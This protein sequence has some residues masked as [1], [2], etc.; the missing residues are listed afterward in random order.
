M[1]FKVGGVYN[2]RT[3]EDDMA[4]GLGIPIKVTRIADGKIWIRGA[5]LVATFSRDA[6]STWVDTNPDRDNSCP[7]TLNDEGNEFTCFLEGY[8]EQRYWHQD[9]DSEDEHFDERS[10]DATELHVLHPWFP[11]TN[12][13]D[14][15]ENFHK[16]IMKTFVFFFISVKL[17]VLARRAK[18]TVMERMYAPGGIGFVAAQESFYRA[19][20]SQRIE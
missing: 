20:K 4:G 3:E 14:E 7:I 12:D 13:S 1:R 6:R 18:R 19:A 11:K 17:V 8:T 16:K 15:A 2:A 10:F 9:S 5:D